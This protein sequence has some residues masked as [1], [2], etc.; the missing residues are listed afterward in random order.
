MFNHS[1][2][3]KLVLIVLL[4]FGS[5][6]VVGADDQPSPNRNVPPVNKP[7]ISSEAKELATGPWREDSFDRGIGLISD[8]QESV[9]S[10][11]A[12]MLKL[13]SK[14]RQLNAAERARFLR[15][16]THLAKDP[17]ESPELRSTA[18]REMASTSLLMWEAGEL[19]EEQAKADKQ[20]LIQTMKDKQLDVSMRASAVN[21]VNTLTIAEARDVLEDLLSDPEDLK[22]SEIVRSGCLA[23]VHIAGNESLNSISRIHSETNDPNVFGTSAYCLRQIKSP[24]A[25]ATLMQNDKRFPDAGSATF[26]LVDMEDVIC[27]TLLNSVD[28]N[29]I[30]G[31]QATKHLWRPGQ[32]DRYMPL[33]YDL[34][35]RGDLETRKEVVARL[36]EEAQERP[37]DE[38]MAELSVV[39]SIIE[40]QPDLTDDA[41]MIRQRLTAKKVI[42]QISDEPVPH[43]GRAGARPPPR[44]RYAPR[45]SRLRPTP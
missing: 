11:Q 14:R 27:A 10:R 35:E 24:K 42:P 40:N 5:I 23:L 39:L 16:S 45:Q 7:S 30:S 37:F 32:K 41:D 34:L 28:P 13:A 15:E 8:P 2:S 44:V 9:D 29:V 4:V 26:N 36:F 38:E 25:V 3:M 12:V 33:L 43:G 21:A 18:V 17:D 19:T 6:S 20:F 22:Q 31:V 1:N